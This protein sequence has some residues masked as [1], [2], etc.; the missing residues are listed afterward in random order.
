M[1]RQRDYAAEYRRRIE[2][3]QGRGF[4]PAELRA[5]VRSPNVAA[6]VPDFTRDASGRITRIRVVVTDVNGKQRTH[7]IRKPTETQIRNL[8]KLV[9]DAGVPFLPGYSGTAK[10]GQSIVTPGGPRSVTRG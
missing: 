5:S 10:A 7:D 6:V 3:G 2:R 4:H 8:S 9:D 1:A